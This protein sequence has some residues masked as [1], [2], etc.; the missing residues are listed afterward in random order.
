M[1]LPQRILRRILDS[2]QVGEHLQDSLN[3]LSDAH[4]QV[5]LANHTSI[6]YE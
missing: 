1:G 3:A 2:L 4:V 6:M 5:I